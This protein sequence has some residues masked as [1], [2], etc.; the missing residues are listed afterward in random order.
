MQGRP[1][2]TYVPSR[3]KCDVAGLEDSKKVSNEEYGGVALCRPTI[4][5]LRRSSSDDAMT[6]DDGDNG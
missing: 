3:L 2:W 4:S 1:A 5:L 6:L